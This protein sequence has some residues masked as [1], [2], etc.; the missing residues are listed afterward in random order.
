MVLVKSNYASQLTITNFMDPTVGSKISKVEAI[1]IECPGGT[2]VGT[3]LIGPYIKAGE[4]VVGVTAS[5][6]ATEPVEFNFGFNAYGEVNCGNNG[7]FGKTPVSKMTVGVKSGYPDA[8]YTVDRYFEVPADGNY[9]FINHGAKGTILNV[10][11][12]IV[13]ANNRNECDWTDIKSATVGNEDAVI[14][15]ENLKAG[16]KLVV[17]SDAFGVIGEGADN[18][19]YLLVTSDQSGIADITT[20]ASAMTATVAGNKLTVSGAILAGALK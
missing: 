5:E 13:N 10:G 14:T 18:L 15:L 9:T 6:T 3:G 8:Y 17:E 1:H 7:G 2:N 4:T 19:P 11:K 12:V 20:D 16:D